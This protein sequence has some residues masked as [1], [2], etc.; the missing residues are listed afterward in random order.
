LI[1]LIAAVVIGYAV[2][3]VNDDDSHPPTTSSAPAP[4]PTQLT[5]PLTTPPSGSATAPAG[6]V[7]LT[8]LPPQAAETLALIDKGGP[9]PYPRN[10]GVV[11]H[12]AGAVL[13]RHPDGWYHEFTVPTPGAS[14]RGARR[15]VTGKDGTV[16]YTGDHYAHFVRVDV[17]G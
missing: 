4:S 11:F 5:T 15:I 6:A 16:Y 1:V 7:A 17:S 3:A 13:P 14:T 12:N 2:N 10:D 9:Y 8:S